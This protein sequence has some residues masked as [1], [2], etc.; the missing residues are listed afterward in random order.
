[1]AEDANTSRQT[2]ECKIG[3]YI[4]FHKTLGGLSA[5]LDHYMI[6]DPNTATEFHRAARAELLISR[7]NGIDLGNHLATLINQQEMQSI[8]TE[9]NTVFF[10]E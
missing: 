1:M 6:I 4:L 3:L 8:R 9:C 7:F 10:E 2:L 5:W